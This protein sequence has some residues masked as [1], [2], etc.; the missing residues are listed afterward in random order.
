MSGDLD[1]FDLWGHR[2]RRR[3]GLSYSVRTPSLKFVGLSVPKVWL[4]FGHGINR[5]SDLDLWPFDLQMGSR[6]T[7]VMCFALA[8]FLLA[9]A[10]RPL[11]RVR[12]GTD[13]QT[14]HD[15]PTVWGRG[16]KTTVTSKMQRRHRQNHPFALPIIMSTAVVT[17]TI[18]LQF[19]AHST[20]YQR[21]LRSQWRNPLA[22]VTMTCLFN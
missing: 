12:Y 10:F 11:I 9:K 22:A 20:A 16:I 19:D 7:R 21:S 5:P 18:R 8:N 15:V 13:R 14:L 17:T 1:L 2:A 3:C 6:V 4:I